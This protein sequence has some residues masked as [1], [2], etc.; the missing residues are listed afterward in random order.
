MP[1]LKPEGI[2]LLGLS[3]APVLSSGMERLYLLPPGSLII[4]FLTPSV[5]A[6]EL[7]TFPITK[8]P[9]SSSPQAWSVAAEGAQ[10]LEASLAH[11][12]STLK[13]SGHP[14]RPRWELQRT[15]ASQN[16]LEALGEKRRGRVRSPKGHEHWSSL[17]RSWPWARVRCAPTG[18]LRSR[19]HRSFADLRENGWTIVIATEGP[20][21]ARRIRTILPKPKCR[22]PRR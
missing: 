2:L 8:S 16:S 3:P 7:R 5:R 19:L 12:S 20:G 10:T 21:P 6:L 17:P 15:A 11:P 22:R 4:C 1:R 13:N 9:R 14:I 18:R